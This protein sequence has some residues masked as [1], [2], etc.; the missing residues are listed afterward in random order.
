MYIYLRAQEL[1][2]RAKKEHDGKRNDR[3]R[4]TVRVDIDVIRDTQEWQQL[5]STIIVLA[6]ACSHTAFTSFYFFAPLR[7][8]PSK[9]SVCDGEVD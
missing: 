6:A 4:M 8:S 7:I 1:E 3:N 5:S 2:E 9:I